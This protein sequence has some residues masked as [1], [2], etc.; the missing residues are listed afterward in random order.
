MPDPAS[1]RWTPEVVIGLLS[2][3]ASLILPYLDVPAGVGT[4]CGVFAAW[5]LG[6]LP[7][8]L[9]ARGDQRGEARAELVIGLLL[10]LAAV[11]GAVLISALAGCG[12]VYQ[13]ERR[14][15]VDIWPGPPC[16]VE[17]RLDGE[18]K[19]TVTVDAPTACPVRP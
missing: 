10:V 19:P 2:L 4:A 18:K 6:P 9:S 7:S 3:L 5:F 14:A 17:V 8:P 13:A 12:S 16:H 1:S 11:G 15:D